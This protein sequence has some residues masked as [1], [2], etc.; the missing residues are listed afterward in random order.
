MAIRTNPLIEQQIC[1]L[2]N[3]G[4]GTCELSNLYDI[5]ITTIAK[6]L[7][8]NNIIRYG[9]RKPKTK[10]DIKFFSQYSNEACY[11][12]GFIYA[13]GCVTNKYGTHKVHIG[14]QKDDVEHLFNFMKLINFGGKLVS[15]PVNN[16]N[17]LNISGKW[18]VEDLEKNFNII[19][20]KS[21]IIRFPEQL[22]T[23][24]LSHF[25]RG[26]FDGDGCVTLSNNKGLISVVGSLSTIKSIVE[27]FYQFTGVRT[28][29]YGDNISGKPRIQKMR[30]IYAVSYHNYA[31]K[32]VLDW[33]YDGATSDIRLERKYLKYKEYFTADRMLDKRLKT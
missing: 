18:F 9:G 24:K 12:A 21:L 31:A 6:M 16:C 15:S 30:N 7:D 3:D 8:R 5:S 13:D 2:Y 20:N 4:Y 10:Y 14:L 22:P 19:P 17:I 23:K 11:W 32:T 33:L 1:K 26:I 28:G 25:I 29:K 27:C